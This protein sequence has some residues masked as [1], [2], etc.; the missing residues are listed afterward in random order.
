MTTANPNGPMI[1]SDDVEGT[2]VYSTDSREKIGDI[3]HLMIDKRSGQIGYAVMSFGGFL[4]IGEKHYPIPWH[5]L[6]Y[7]T[8]LDG[9][10]T[11]ITER[12]LENAPEEAT[13]HDRDWETRLHDNYEAPYYWKT[14]PYI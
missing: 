6:K 1:S 2:D 8:D 11:G 9:Y 3:H 4:G 7:D 12:Q 5:A 13:W 14:T 10:V